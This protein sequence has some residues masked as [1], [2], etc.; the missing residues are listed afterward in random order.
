M[1]IALPTGDRLQPSGP[2]QSLVGVLRAG[3][4]PL[5]FGLR[6]W[7]SVSLALYIAFWLQLDNPYWAGASAAIVCQPQLGASL[8]KGWFR[9]IGTLIGAVMSV[10]LTA[11]FPQDRALFLGSLALWA[12]TCAGVATLLRNFA[13]YAAALAGYTAA[14]VAGGLLGLTGGVDA[15]AGFLLAV[16]RASEICL[17][18]ACAGV[19]LALTDFGGARRRLAALVGAVSSDIAAGF[20]ATLAS[21]GAGFAETQGH[22]RDLLRRVIALDPIIDQAFGESAELRYYSPVLQRAVD[23]LYVALAGWRTVS[24]LFS[25][26]RRGEAREI[27]DSVL[28]QAPAEL[29]AG[30]RAD[31]LAQP[32][33]LRGAANRAARKLT[34]MP[35]DTL[36]RRLLADKT[37]AVFSN[38]SRALDVLALLMADPSRHAAR[39][40]GGFRRPSIPDWLPAVVNGGRTLVTVAGVALF[41]IVTAWPGGSQA[42]VFA[43]I[44]SVLMA[45]HAEVAYAA[46][47]I[48]V[49]GVVFNVV[50]TAIVAFAV[51]P[52]SGVETFAGLSVVLGA[53]LVPL[54]IFLARAHEPWQVGLFGVMTMTFVMLLAPTN[55]M[56]Y[57][58][59]T[60]YNTSLG[61]VVGAGAATSAFRLIP[62]LSPAYRTRRLLG[63]ALG[64]L[65]RL[66]CRHI[67]PTVSAWDRRGISRLSGLP[68]SA[69]PIE[70]A[71]LL[72]A[73]LVGAEIVRLRRVMRRLG[74]DAQLVAVLARLAS[75]DTAGATAGLAA[76]DERLAP[77]QTSAVVGA[78]A[79]ILAISGAL[80]QHAAYFERLA[81][82]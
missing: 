68:D 44:V 55:Q 22:R 63:L 5:L 58:V 61:I 46:A 53:C 73:I 67:V 79:R 40:R 29:R 48:A 32:L 17:G 31:W 60:F 72:A 24:V 19:V 13:S 52:G 50:L 21:A 43:T 18:I 77:R 12:A 59:A 57:D 80:A 30:I 49:V 47:F 11:C 75:G 15:N 41:W 2:A 56:N 10:L 8:R 7:A 65:R 78:R 36:P 71:Q 51:L 34:T 69:A 28:P 3:G 54:G 81:V 37:A 82:A 4:P 23:G 20:I 70:R 42:I 6:L 27:A 26:L 66:L 38:L 39:R 45:P 9:M 33:A 14:I 16:A 25:L 64:D 62:P 35:V 76:L 1:S 74:L